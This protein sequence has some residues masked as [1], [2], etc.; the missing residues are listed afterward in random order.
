MV[1]HLVITLHY[2]Y[3]VTVHKQLALSYAKETSSISVQ[4]YV[5]SHFTLLQTCL[6]L[7]LSELQLF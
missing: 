3:N 1:I 2:I 7:T 6:P 4:P 5:Y